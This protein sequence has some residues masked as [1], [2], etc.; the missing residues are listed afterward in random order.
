MSYVDDITA[1]LQDPGRQYAAGIELLRENNRNQVLARNLAA[2]ESEGNFKT[3]EYH[4]R[5]LAEAEPVMRQ[6]EEQGFRPPA[7]ATIII[8][9]PAPAE[10]PATAPAPELSAEVRAR[11]DVISIESGKLYQEQ[12]RL[13]NT[14]ADKK[15]DAERS[16]TIGLIESVKAVRDK[17][18]QER[19]HLEAGGS[20]APAAP[21]APTL[22]EL[23]QRRDN[24]RARVSKA[25][26]AAELKPDDTAKAAKLVKLRTELEEMELAVRHARE[27]SRL[28][29][30]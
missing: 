12:A 27:Q 15:T 10:T 11:L 5:Q 19:Q 4:L 3:L 13:S 14:L 2:R 8:M 29:H 21:A 25:K 9:Q 20:L 24:L 16:E 26:K 30:A 22:D 6:L 17:L 7:G 18:A 28:A 23:E 1:W